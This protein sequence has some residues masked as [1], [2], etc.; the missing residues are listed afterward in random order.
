MDNLEFSK[1]KLWKKKKGAGRKETGTGLIMISKGFKNIIANRV[2]H[3]F[4]FSYKRR[5]KRLA[6]K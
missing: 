3:L 4:F 5:T 6:I 2:V 1:T